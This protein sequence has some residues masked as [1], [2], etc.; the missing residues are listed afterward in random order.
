M[1]VS[2]EERH[3]E[4]GRHE[5]Q[6][7]VGLAGQQVPQHDQQEVRKLVALMDLI[8]HDVGNAFQAVASSQHAQQHAVGAEH[9]RAVGAPSAGT[10]AIAACRVGLERS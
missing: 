10:Q 8:H 7:Q 2:S 3:I 5:H 9:E 1:E 4:G 6:V